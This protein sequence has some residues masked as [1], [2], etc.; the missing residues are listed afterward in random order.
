V[1]IMDDSTSSVDVETEGR[2]LR[3]LDDL[4][5]GTTRL[6]VA[7]RISSILSADR[8]VVLD[9]GRIVASGTHRELMASSPI[10]QDIYRSQL[11]NGANDEAGGL[12]DDGKSA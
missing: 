12:A 7:Q 1:L 8:V 2:I 6:V 10:Y 9:R 11:G 3:A 4:M 5:A